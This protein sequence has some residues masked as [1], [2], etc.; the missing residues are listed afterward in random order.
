MNRRI[1]VVLI[2]FVL[3]IPWLLVSSNFFYSIKSDYSDLV[4]SHLPNA[5]YLVENI[6]SGGGIPYWSHAILS[7]APFAADPLSGIWYPPGWLAYF[8][9][10]PF[11]F[12]LVVLLHFLWGGLGLYFLLMQLGVKRDSAIFG[13]VAFL[14]M[15]KIFAHMAAGN[16]SLVYAVS[17]TPWLFLAEVGRSP[18]RTRSP[19]HRILAG[20]ILGIIALADP[21]WTVYAGAGWVFYSIWLTLSRSPEQKPVILARAWLPD[22]GLQ[23]LGALVVAA[24]LILPMMEFSRL[25]T[26]S[27]MAA[28]DILN[29]SLPPSQLIGVFLP[30]I[31]GYAEWQVYPGALVVLLFFYAL[32]TQSTRK[33]S[34]F[35]LVLASVTLIFSLGSLWPGS[36]YLANLPLFDLTRV[37]SRAWFLTGMSLIVTAAI[38]YD[39]LKASMVA[40][41][42]ID[43]LLILF[44]LP[45]FAV[46]LTTG[47]LVVGQKP[48]SGFIWGAIAMVISYAAI[49]WLRKWPLARVGGA[50][51]VILVAIDLGGVNGLGIKLRSP[52]EVFSEGQAAAEFLAAQSGIFRIYSPSYSIPQQ[53]AAAFGLELVDGINPLQLDAYASY[54]REASGVEADGYSVTLPPYI[55]AN[56]RVDNAL[57]IPDTQLLGLLN[58]K[59]IVSAFE[60]RHP[61]LVLVWQEDGTRV[62]ENLDAKPRAWL[63]PVDS[64]PGESIIQTIDVVQDTS[65]RL[66]ARVNGNGLV[67]ISIPDYPGWDL[68]VDGR[69]A[70]IVRV[71]NLLIGVE[72]E[73]GQHEL[74]LS[75][76]PNILVWSAMISSLA[77]LG[78]IGCAWISLRKPRGD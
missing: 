59:Y 42:K 23:I 65:D 17:W 45:C 25:S 76:S 32:L 70:N 47:L 26:R 15:P 67:I 10:Q 38:A 31:G 7:G 57:A 5:M 51:F 72:L 74:G 16:I 6:R 63:Q 77:W 8:L 34:G 27:S 37:P 46:L 53:T 60:I 13:A 1:P 40:K 44:L 29:F 52:S 73:E 18:G 64:L 12:N 39:D 75:F 69:K 61:R 11:G 50:A 62:Y 41:R 9:P 48:P 36:E 56:P 30:D 20:V 19:I 55:T 22:M 58:A 28:G 43:P 35:W 66:I 71:A 24:A 21:R 14:L 33:R 68:E 3:L 4:I 2:L 78:L 49:L 54:M